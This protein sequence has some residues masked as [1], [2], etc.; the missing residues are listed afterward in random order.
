V[1]VAQPVQQIE[2]LVLSAFLPANHADLALRF[3]RE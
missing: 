2:R 3:L 1:I